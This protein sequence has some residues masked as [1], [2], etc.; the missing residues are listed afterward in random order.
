M[1]DNKARV[2]WRSLGD[3]VET[4]VCTAELSELE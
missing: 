4:E 1:Y 2:I 3:V